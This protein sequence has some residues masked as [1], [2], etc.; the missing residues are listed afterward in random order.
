MSIRVD[1]AMVKPSS[2]I[3]SEME[4]RVSEI[5][6]YVWDP[7]GVNRMP[8][9]RDEYADYVPLITAYLLDHFPESGVDALLTYIAEEHM[10]VRLAK[11]PRRKAQHLEAL[12]LLLAWK[13]ELSSQYPQAAT[14]AAA[15]PKDACF[16]DQLLWS[17][18]CAWNRTMH[19]ATAVANDCGTGLAKS[20]AGTG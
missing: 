16:A 5:L 13:S 14:S 3:Q 12:R 9:C 7:I 19:C 15:F 10:G 1:G 20:H 18:A 2:H 6:F 8:A 4:Q 17:R 11:P